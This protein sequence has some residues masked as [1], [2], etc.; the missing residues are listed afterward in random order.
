M[1]NTELRNISAI[2]CLEA[3]QRNPGITCRNESLLYRPVSGPTFSGQLNAGNYPNYQDPVCNSDGEYFCD[4]SSILNMEERKGLVRELTKLRYNNPV[5]CGYRLN[6]PVDPRH[7]QPFYLGVAMAT[8]W[9]A[10][11]SDPDS[12]QQLGQVIDADWNMGNKF[13]GPHIP[14]LRCPNTAILIFMPEIR[15]AFVSSASCEFICQD[16]GGP[17]VATAA[18]LAMD[19]GGPVAA[20]RAAMLEAYR[21]V[22]RDSNNAWKVQA[23]HGGTAVGVND[24]EQEVPQATVMQH[25]TQAQAQS[26]SQEG[27]TSLLIQRVLYGVALCALVASVFAA[28]MF[29]FVSPGWLFTTRLRRRK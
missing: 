6:D 18:L 15:R 26:V 9:P 17:E 20:V 11:E 10:G 14:Y 5:T 27:T 16:R 4:P 28:L 7:Y 2:A 29:L 12:L 13:V 8:K 19:K 3:R 23:S 24:T 22:S 21:V 1:T 25:D